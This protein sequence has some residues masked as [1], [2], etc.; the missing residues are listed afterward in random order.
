MLMGS[1]KSDQLKS[2][3]EKLVRS[4]KGVKNIDNKIVVISS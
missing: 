1:V 4:I 2:Q 3:V